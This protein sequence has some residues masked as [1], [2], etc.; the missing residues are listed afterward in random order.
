MKVR[1]VAACDDG[2]CAYRIQFLDI[3]GG[4]IQ[5]YNPDKETDE[6][7]EH[8]FGETEELIGVYGVKDKEYEFSSFGFILKRKTHI[9]FKIQSTLN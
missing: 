9:W 7:T 5:E 1:A 4:L 2:D 8:A 6:V 3:A